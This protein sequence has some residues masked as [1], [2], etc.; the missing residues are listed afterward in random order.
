MYNKVTTDTESI[1]LQLD[2]NISCDSSVITE[3]QCSCCDKISRWDTSSI[4]DIEDNEILGSPI[5]ILVNFCM[6]DSSEKLDP[7]PW[8]EEYY[9]W[10]PNPRQSKMNR[11]T[12]KRDNRVAKSEYLP[13]SI[14]TLT[15]FLTFCCY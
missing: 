10:C 4:S 6:G 5:P 15:P 14:G 3:S 8:Y 9:S 7:P 11:K 12:I 2:G 1:I 13:H